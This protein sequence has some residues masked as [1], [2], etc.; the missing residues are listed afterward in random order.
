MTSY[1]LVLLAGGRATR[2]GALAKDVPK[3]LQPVAGRP[4]LYHLMEHAAAGGITDVHLCLGHLGA[5]VEEHVGRLADLTGLRFT[6]SGETAPAGTA[7][8]LVGA[9]DQLADTFVVGMG[10]TYIDLD[11]PAVAGRLP[12]TA[13]AMMVVTG[14]PSGPPPNVLVRDGLVTAYDKRGIAGAWTD[15]G[16]AVLRKEALFPLRG[17]SVP[18]DLASLFDP[19]IGR[20][21]LAALPV[22]IR[23]YDIGTP[24]RIEEIERRHFGA[25][26]SEGRGG[27][28]HGG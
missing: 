3:V 21:D 19:L 7:G 10:D 4:F 14:R 25:L 26:S 15:T 28:S 8:A 1:Q 9:L 16:V 5:R 12:S 23:F 22:D 2:L 11:W 18:C 20:G 6:T 24:E 17:H 13:P 27:R